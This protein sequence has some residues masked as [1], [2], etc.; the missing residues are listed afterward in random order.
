MKLHWFTGKMKS[1]TTR[2][3]SKHLFIKFAKQALEITRESS[4]EDQVFMNLETDF[5]EK[6]Y[7]YKQKAKAVNISGQTIYTLLRLPIN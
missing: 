3:Q 7:Q 5:K 2:K 6:S 4:R 1:L